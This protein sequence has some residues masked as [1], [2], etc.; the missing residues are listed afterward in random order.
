MK[1]VQPQ[2]VE[3]TAKHRLAISRQSI[4]AEANAPLWAALVRWYIRR[5]V[6][7]LAHEECEKK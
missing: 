1:N 5:A 2:Q 6:Q 4:A 7:K 3:L